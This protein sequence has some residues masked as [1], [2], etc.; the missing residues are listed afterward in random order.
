MKRLEEYDWPGNVRELANVLERAMVLCG[1]K[2]IT[3]A[4][5]GPW[6]SKGAQLQQGD[7]SKWA[8]IPLEEVER[9]VIEGTLKQCGGNREA[10][11]RALGITSRTLRDKLK[12]W[13]AGKDF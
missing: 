9:R 1:G 8:G 5:V 12:R 3:E 10:T 4:L 7:V 13:G 6:L 2:E 11:A